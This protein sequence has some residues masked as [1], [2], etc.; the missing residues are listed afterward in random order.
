MILLLYAKEAE[1]ASWA[2]WGNKKSF[3]LLQILTKEEPQL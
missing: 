3:R 2:V 1:I